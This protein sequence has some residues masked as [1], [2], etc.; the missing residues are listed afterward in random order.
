M[1]PTRHDKGRLGEDVAADYLRQHGVEVVSKNVRC[2]LGEI[3]LVC[4]EG[5]TVVFVEVK[6]RYDAR[7]G[8]PQEAVSRNKQLRLTRLAQWYLK[9]HGL[10][11]QPARFDVIAITWSEGRPEVTWIVNA[12]E[13]CQ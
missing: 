9:K 8:L 1:F 13:A 5:R 2:P 11:R 7:Y 3:D 10:E 4:R 12:F 6:A